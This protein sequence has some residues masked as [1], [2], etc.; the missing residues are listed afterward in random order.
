MRGK[1]LFISLALFVFMASSANAQKVL[2]L[3]KPGKAK[4]V[5]YHVGDKISL[6]TG[7]PAFNVIGE[8]T[9]IEDSLF[10]VNRSFIVELQKVHEV[11]RAR[12]FFQSSYRMQYGAGIFYAGISL[13]NRALHGE[14]PL[15][16]ESVSMA[17][18][19]LI[20]LGITSYLLRN[21]HYKTEDGWRLKVLDFDIYEERK[22]K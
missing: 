21:R 16:D 10:T 3:Q 1:L 2:L 9:Y 4:R 20:V 15:I 8:I 22:K 11:T 7:D 6:R 13:I 19:S 17:S 18:G 14:K 12:H 5:F